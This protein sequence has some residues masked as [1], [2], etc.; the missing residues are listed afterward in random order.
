[1]EPLLLPPLDSQTI[2][3]FHLRTQCRIQ[4]FDSV[5]IRQPGR[6][7]SFLTEYCLQAGASAVPS[8]GSSNAL[9]DQQLLDGVVFNM[10][11]GSR[12]PGSTLAPP[13]C[14]VGLPG[15]TQF[16]MGSH[17]GGSNI[18]RLEKEVLAEALQAGKLN[19]YLD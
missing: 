2:V 18:P 12:G 9:S 19:P 8:A 3:F 11:S 5:H 10:T 6:W 1:M 14:K 17:A 7:H 15:L 4:F 13:C 16:F